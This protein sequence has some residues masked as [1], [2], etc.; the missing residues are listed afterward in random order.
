[1]IP[2]IDDDLGNG[3][4]KEEW[5]GGAETNKILGRGSSIAPGV[6]RRGD[7]IAFESLCVRVG[8][9]RSHSQALTLKLR[10]DIPVDEIEQIIAEGTDWAE[11]VPNEKDAT[12]QQ[13]T[14]V[15]ATGELSIPVGRIRQLERGT[16]YISDYTVGEQ[17]VR[18]AAEQHRRMHA[19]ARG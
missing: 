14:P 2:W 12:M 19:N 7:A 10:E 4:S 18:G 5:K 11:V 6:T 16:E 3:M 8:A 17:M 13:L 9:L 1:L 15:A